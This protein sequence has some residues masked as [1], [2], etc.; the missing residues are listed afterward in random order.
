MERRP[1]LFRIFLSLS[2]LVGCGPS[3]SASCRVAYYCIDYAGFPN[4]ELESLR[5]ECNDRLLTLVCKMP[6]TSC[7]RGEWLDGACTQHIKAVGGCRR[8][9]GRKITTT[10]FSVFTA[11]EIEASCSDEF[12]LP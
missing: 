11:S 6:G 2:L 7:P 8:T 4:T 1:H 10:W 9:E 12:V 5:Q 3:P